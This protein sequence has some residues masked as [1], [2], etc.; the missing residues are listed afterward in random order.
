[1]DR[2]VTV[3]AP[4]DVPVYRYANGRHPLLTQLVE[5]SRIA[6]FRPVERRAP[7]LA[8]LYRAM[9][10]AD[11]LGG[12]LSAALPA[13][14]QDGPEAIL[15]YLLSRDVESQAQI[16]GDVDL[17]FHHTTP[18]TYGATP[19]VLHVENVT[20]LF[21]PFLSHGRTH[22]VELWREPAFAIVRAVLAD[23][24]CRGIL[25]HMQGTVEALH[26]VFRSDAVSRKVR[27]APLGVHVPAGERERIAAAMAAKHRPGR[28][29]EI[30]FTN[31]WHQG[32]EN[33]FTRG[34]LEVIDAF[35]AVHRV[36]PDV[37]LTIRSVIPDGV[38]ESDLG[39]AVLGHPAITV[40]DEA[41]SDAALSE[42]F[43]AADVFLLPSAAL[44]SVSTLRAMEYGAVCVVSDLPAFREF[45]EPDVT[46][47]VVPGRWSR[48]YT[49]DP[50]S[51]WEQDDYAALQ[52]LDRGVADSLGQALLDLCRDPERRRALAGRAQAACAGRFSF[53][54]FRDG[55]DAML[56]EAAA[57]GPVAAPPLSRQLAERIAG[58]FGVQPLDTEAR[59]V[60]VHC[61]FNI[62]S[63]NGRYYAIRQSLG[64]VEVEDGADALV[65]RLGADNVGVAGD[66][67]GARA[68]IEATEQALG[69]PDVVE[70]YRG[71]NVVRYRRSV[72]G[73]RQDLDDVDFTVD[74][75]ELLRRHPEGAL[76]VAVTPDGVRLLIDRANAASAREDVG[77]YRGF[78][79]LRRAG[80]LYGIRQSLGDLD[81]TG[82]GGDW[83]ARYDGWNVAAAPDLE[84]LHARIDRIEYVVGGP[85]LV[86]SEGEFN[87][88]LYK[89]A[90]YGIRQSLGPVDLSVGE[91]ALLEKY[92][93]RDLVLGLSEE[94][95]RQRIR[96]PRRRFD[97]TAMLGRR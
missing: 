52:T 47:V 67:P 7:D 26:R 74:E 93:S 9:R 14:L 58:R 27:Y 30:L 95:V 62:L 91:V 53:E 41:V 77:E 37:H 50:E 18:L 97:M 72:Y 61:G 75:A 51:G 17:V 57:A 21:W 66:L 34:G 23:D 49:T 64:Y 79:I 1:M 60:E 85:M 40:L 76:L 63:L 71:F 16:P 25:T 89:G 33:F 29:V 96:T 2:S 36:F 24:A 32:P 20:T 86:G 70:E 81:L 19:W 5:H 69:G 87:I 43:L 35:L 6:R 78:N 44:H 59:L 4:F 68:W 15:A 8:A 48:V 12:R 82:G 31:S 3:A 13:D 11:D 83:L 28:T 88:V 42:L 65:R 46:G 39:R 80:L 92:Q 84:T 90:Y 45:I 38:R 54:G 56:A 94:G 55:F 73:V 10:Q 22:G